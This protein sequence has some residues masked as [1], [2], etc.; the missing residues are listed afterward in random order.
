M[1]L[2]VRQYE[3]K[4]RILRPSRLIQEQGIED[5]ELVIAHGLQPYPQHRPTAGEML[6]D[7]QCIKSGTNP[8]YAI[9]EAS[10]HGKLEEIQ[11]LQY[12]QAI[13]ESEGKRDQARFAQQDIDRIANMQQIDKDRLAVYVEAFKQTVYH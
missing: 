2:N 1:V 12:N 13:M 10:E 4:T 5:I 7:L 8:F 9:R 3:G 6:T 11:R